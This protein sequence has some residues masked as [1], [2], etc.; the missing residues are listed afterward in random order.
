MTED[1]KPEDMKITEN[2]LVGKLTRSKTICEGR[3]LTFRIAVEKK[4]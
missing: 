3:H 2:G 1:R 4:C